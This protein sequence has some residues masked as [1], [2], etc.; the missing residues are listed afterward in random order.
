MYGFYAKLTW[1]VEVLADVLPMYRK[2]NNHCLIT[3]IPEGGSSSF[4]FGE[5][6]L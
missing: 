3:I 2:N 4:F 5:R 6:E 1:A